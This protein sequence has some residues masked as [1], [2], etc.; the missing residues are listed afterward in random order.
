MKQTSFARRT[1]SEICSLEGT[2]ARCCKTAELYGLLLFSMS[3]SPGLVKLQAENKDV[4]G[5]AALL[6]AELA[7]VPLAI[8][9]KQG[10][11]SDR[12]YTA[13]T[14]TPQ[15]ANML[16]GFFGHAPGELAL[17]INR[18]LFACENCARS[19]LRGAFLSAGAVIDPGKGY[20]LEFA[21]PHIRVGEG[22]CALLGEYGIAARSTRRRGNFVAY[23]KESEGI[24][25]FLNLIGAQNA[26]FDIMNVKIY[27][28]LRNRAN[29]VT[30]CETAN[31][32]KAVGAAAAQLEAIGRLRGAGRFETLPQELIEAAELR[33]QNPDMTL[34]E[35]AAAAGVSKSGMN[36]RLQKLLRAANE[37]SPNQEAP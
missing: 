25:D 21:T 19:F 15:D 32:G 37:C 30:N 1:K 35:L 31:L 27:R 2:G 23:L 20:H 24:E 9:C 4:V 18:A 13:A 7:G 5:R 3:F 11:K 10:A 6:S 22:L 29:R 36:H 26:A 12:F 33:E 17:T 16:T 8:E 28:D 14:E 34:S